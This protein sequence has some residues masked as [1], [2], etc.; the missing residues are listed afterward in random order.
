MSSYKNNTE[1]FSCHY[2]KLEKTTHSTN[3]KKGKTGW[4]SVKQLLIGQRETRL[5]ERGHW[6]FDLPSGNS[7]HHLKEKRIDKRL[8]MVVK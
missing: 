1:S 5:F 4:Y 6:K 7:F 2:W 8:V 3:R